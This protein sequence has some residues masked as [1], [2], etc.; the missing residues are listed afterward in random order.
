MFRFRPWHKILLAS[1]AISGLVVIWAYHDIT[2]NRTILVGGLGGTILLSPGLTML[3]WPKAP[4]YPAVCLVTAAIYTCA[5]F[6]L[7]T[8]G[9]RL[10]SRFG[11]RL[12]TAGTVRINR[13]NL[14]N[15]L[16]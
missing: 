5:L 12:R 2:S 3:G 4:F 8:I 7:W 15:Y 6:G 1:E 16:R 13:D 9:R 10:A 11:R 14:N